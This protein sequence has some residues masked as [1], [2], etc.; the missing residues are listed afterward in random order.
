MTSTFTPVDAVQHYPN[1]LKNQLV[2]KRKGESYFY[3]PILVKK[4]V[5]CKTIFYFG[6]R[7]ERKWHSCCTIREELMTRL[8]I[9]KY[10][11]FLGRSSTWFLFLIPFTV[12]FLIRSKKPKANYRTEI[13]VWTIHYDNYDRK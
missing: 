13:R 12:G 7:M 2:F 1:T 9:N 6:S 11:Q 8:R 5:S 3:A 4:Q 10:S